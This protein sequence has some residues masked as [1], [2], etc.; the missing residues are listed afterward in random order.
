MLL[1]LVCYGGGDYGRQACGVVH[2]AWRLYL[3]R[4]LSIVR[5]RREKLRHLAHT[6][7]SLTHKIAI[8]YKRD[9]L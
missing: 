9:R 6:A 1:P 5:V 4:L 2:G 7:A 8:S 3:I